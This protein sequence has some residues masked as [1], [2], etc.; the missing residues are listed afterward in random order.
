VDFQRDLVEK[1]QNARIAG[2]THYMIIV[3]EGAGSAS[4]IAAKLRETLKLDVR[5]TVL[6]HIQRGGTPTARDRV[7]ATRMGNRA[8]EILADGLTNRIVCVKDGRVIDVSMEEGFQM[9]RT[10]MESDLKVLDTMTGI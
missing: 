6:G 4:E 9:T 10:L 8:V 2:R 1:I 3:A 5:V 7:S